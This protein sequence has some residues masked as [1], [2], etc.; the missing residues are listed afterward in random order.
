MHP[1]DRAIFLHSG[2]DVHQDRMT[3][4]MTVED[5][6]ARQRDLDRTAGNHRELANND[7]VIEGIALAAKAAAIRS[8]DHSNVAGRQL[9]ELSSS[10]R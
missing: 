2:L 3:A 1:G 10:A 5:L 7:L 8:G 4:A 9:P 6:F